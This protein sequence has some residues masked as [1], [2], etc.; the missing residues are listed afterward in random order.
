[1]ARRGLRGRGG[2]HM[3]GRGARWKVGRESGRED[4][5]ECI[6]N[7]IRS[8]VTPMRVQHT[9]TGA[10]QLIRS[11]SG[12]GHAVQSTL[13]LILTPRRKSTPDVFTLQRLHTL[14][15]RHPES[16]RP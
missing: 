10:G 6:A 14:M 7:V 12:S 16:H 9:R 11:A 5:T 3:S 13:T 15:F 2:G 4:G 1:M 8:A